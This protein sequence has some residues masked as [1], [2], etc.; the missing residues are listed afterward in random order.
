M[1]HVL[2]EDIP[3]GRT[4]LTGGYILQEGISYSRTY[5]SGEH[6]NKYSIHWTVF[7]SCYIIFIFF[8]V[9]AVKHDF[10]LLE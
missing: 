9:D 6:V 3:F 1:G 2:R 5:L 7:C 4:C 10:V 8:L